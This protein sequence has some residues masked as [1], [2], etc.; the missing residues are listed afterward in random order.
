MEIRQNE[1]YAITD[2][3]H[4]G[5]EEFVLGVHLKAANQYVTWRC[6]III[7]DI[8]F[9]ICLRHKRILQP[10]SRKKSRKWKKKKVCKPKLFHRLPH[11]RGEKFRPVNPF[12][13]ASIPS[14]LQTTA[15]SWHCRNWLKRYSET[16]PE[17][18]VLS[19]AAIFALRKIVMRQWPCRN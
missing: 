3:F 8:I 16:K 15:E 9:R 6:R 17:P 4:L 5:E 2:S 1:G 10:E 11:R 19:M 12:C 7:G 18:A 13:L 14:S